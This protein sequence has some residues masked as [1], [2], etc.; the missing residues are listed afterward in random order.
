M[1]FQSAGGFFRMPTWAMK[2]FTAKQNYA[3]SLRLK[4]N[5]LD[6]ISK[7]IFNMFPIAPCDRLIFSHFVSSLF[8]FCNEISKTLDDKSGMSFSS[9]HEIFFDAEVHFKRT[10][11]KP[12]TSALS[13]LGGLSHFCDAENA[14]I[15]GP[16]IVLSPSRHRN[17]NVI[18]M[19]NWHSAPRHLVEGT[20]MQH[21]NS[22]RNSASPVS[23][24][25]R[26]QGL[27]RP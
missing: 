20:N 27:P 23:N 6:P 10:A 22:G 26:Q 18:Y 25:L 17:Q 1:S 15:K 7:G 4:L 24:S 9:R 12:A 2:L 13:E 3:A 21:V 14:V 8:Y 5:Q 19:M 11:F 16:R